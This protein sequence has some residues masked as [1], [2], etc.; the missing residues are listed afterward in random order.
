MVNPFSKFASKT[1][2]RSR[3]RSE[4]G[5]QICLLKTVT[6]SLK[7]LKEPPAKLHIWLDESHARDPFEMIV[8]HAPGILL[9]ERG[10]THCARKRKNKRKLCKPM[11]T[12]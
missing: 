7:T 1:N 4:I 6:S 9:L 3:E 5:T 2:H 8:T 10:G 12:D 11:K